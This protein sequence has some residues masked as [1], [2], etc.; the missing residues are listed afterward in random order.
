[1]F[2]LIYQLVLTPFHAAEQRSKKRKSGSAEYP[3]GGYKHPQ[4]VRLS[5]T[6]SLYEQRRVAEGQVIGCTFF[7]S[8]HYA[9]KEMNIKR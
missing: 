4:G 3:A 1:L 5:E 2:C 6:P 9:S 8:F 7:G